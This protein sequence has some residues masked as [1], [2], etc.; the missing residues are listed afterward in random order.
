MK[1]L[2]A[3]GGCAAALF[4]AW[5]LRE[6][7]VLGARE[8]ARRAFDED[9]YRNGVAAARSRCAHGFV[10]F[11][12]SGIPGMVTVTKKWCAVCRCD[13]GAAKLIESFLGNYWT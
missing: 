13:L 6:R 3:L 5:V 11:T 10:T 2:V 8:A 1:I 4:G 7:R 9:A 12:Q